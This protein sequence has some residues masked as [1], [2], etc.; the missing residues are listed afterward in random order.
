MKRILITGAFGQLGVEMISVLGKQCDLLATD[1]VIPEDFS[2]EPFSVV[3]DITSPR[4][5]KEVI[6]AYQPDVVVNLAAMTDVDACELHPDQS[7]RVNRDGVQY[8]LEN[9]SGYFIQIS[10]DY[11]FDGTAGPYSE[12]D[13]PQP[14]NQYG[15]SKLSAERLL[16]SSPN[17]TL[18]LRTNV[19]Y[20]YTK[21]TRASFVK[22]VV[23]S[24]KEGQSIPVVDDQWNNPTWTRAL[25]ETVHSLLAKDVEGM[26]H[27]GG[28][29]LLNRYQFAQRIASVFHLDSQLIR[30][31]K[32]EAL[33]QPAPRPLR[34]GLKTEKIEVEWHQSPLPV[35]EGL[36]QIRKALE[37]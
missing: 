33:K 5:V 23:D 4:Q 11:V 6:D 25:A 10:T 20:G 1:T 26:Y 19:L 34:S 27:Y 3:M 22:W 24:L 30:P 7:Q 36:K 15:R 13:P 8:L 18:I 28:A 2:A 31:V 35:E 17:R 32:T 16:Q 9:F 14:I 37:A 29:E 12:T 21:R